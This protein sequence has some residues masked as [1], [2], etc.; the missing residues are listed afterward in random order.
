MVPPKPDPM[1]WAVPPTSSS[2]T[3]IIMSASR[4]FDNSGFPV[5]YKFGCFYI[6]GVF[7]GTY[8]FYDSGWLAPDTYVIDEDI[9]A[10]VASGWEVDTIVIEESEPLNSTKNEADGTATIV[11]E[12]GETVT[13]TFTNEYVE[14]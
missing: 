8:P 11:L 3:S 4:A 9:E 2:Q 7:S 1:T 6:D 10:L 5:E 12:A 14:P 13:V